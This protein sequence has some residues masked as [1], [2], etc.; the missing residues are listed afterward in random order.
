MTNIR[1]HRHRQADHFTT[2]PNAL[3]QDESLSWGARGLVS[4]LLSLPEDWIIQMTDVMGR[5]T[6]GKARFYSLKREL[7]A[8]GYLRGTVDR[9]ARGVIISHVWEVTDKPGGFDAPSGREAE[10]EMGEPAQTSASSPVSEN[11]ESGK[12]PVRSP[13]SDFPEGGEPRRWE[14]QNLRKPPSGNPPTTKETI[15][16]DTG[17]KDTLS[18]AG[19][20]GLPTVFDPMALRYA[21]LP[22]E[23]SVNQVDPAFVEFVISVLPKKDNLAQ[24]QFVADAFIRKARQVE[25]RYEQVLAQWASYQKQQE[26]KQQ[27]EQA[28][29][30][31]AERAKWLGRRF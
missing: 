25:A 1:I 14:T 20:A 21:R 19:E 9:D 30:E 5:A 24:A 2:L 28:R 29:V 6:D 13:D 22:W 7:E 31:D 18:G 8:T 3:L 12:N 15:T 17:T 4:Y 16:K 11:P 23:V 27:A 26:Q 10:P